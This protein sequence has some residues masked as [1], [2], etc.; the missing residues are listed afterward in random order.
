M[1]KMF[2]KKKIMFLTGI[3]LTMMMLL[4][5][6]NEDTNDSVVP[7]ESQ[8]AVVDQGEDSPYISLEAAKAN[9]NSESYVFVDARLS[10]AYNGWALDGISR[11]GH[12]PN[13]VDF[14]YNW[15]TVEVDDQEEQLSKALETKNITKD[16][17]II[18]YD[19]E[20]TNALAVY[21]YLSAKGF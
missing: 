14:P 19:V 12:I 2:R 1:E 8:E 3:L 20:G 6:C 11:G 9:Y 15:L 21:D 18:V 5:A 7:E 4:V 16:K 17:K 10:D 13:A